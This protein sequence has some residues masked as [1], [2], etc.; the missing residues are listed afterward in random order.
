[1]TLQERLEPTKEINEE[2]S[3]LLYSL[4]KLPYHNPIALELR[5]RFRLKVEKYKVIYNLDEFNKLYG[6]Y[7]K[8]KLELK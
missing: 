5:E 4:F 1:M 2:L 6:Q 8:D 3:T 7:V